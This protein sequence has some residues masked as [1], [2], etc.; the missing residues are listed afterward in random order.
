M[1]KLAKDPWGRAYIYE[2]DGESYRLKSLGADQREGGAG[3]G[4][5]IEL[6]VGSF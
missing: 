1:K 6:R 3:S 2:S 5:D 4:A